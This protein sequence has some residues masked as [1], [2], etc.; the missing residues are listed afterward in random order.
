RESGRALSLITEP[1]LT[2][3]NGRRL[4]DSPERE[5]AHRYHRTGRAPRSETARAIE[6][7][8]RLERA[9]VEREERREGGAGD[10]TS[11]P[12]E[13]HPAA[14]RRAGARDSRVRTSSAVASPEPR[15]PATNFRATAPEAAVAAGSARRLPRARERSCASATQ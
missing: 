2:K 4:S 12:V 5:I 6:A 1:T 9:A 7:R 10:R 13:S 15:L 11:K 8:S 14:P 3:F